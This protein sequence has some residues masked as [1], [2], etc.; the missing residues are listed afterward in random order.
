MWSKQKVV[1]RLAK[2]SY[3]WQKL[4]NNVWKSSPNT[5]L[6]FGEGVQFSSVQS[7]HQLGCQGTWRTIQH[8]SSFSLFR[9]RP[10]WAV[11]AWADMS[12]LWCCPSNISSAEHRV[13]HP[14]R[15]LERWFWVGR[16]GV[17]RARTMHVSVS[18]Q[19][20]EEVSVDQPTP[21][22]KKKGVGGGGGKKKRLLW[23]LGRG[24]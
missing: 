4:E 22:L 2:S 17:W 7:L 23:V 6:V 10:L 12:T 8:R 19:L 18:W 24:T 16:H 15:C 1:C 21:G 14:P 5:G 9:R 20:P 11:L 3:T 13:T